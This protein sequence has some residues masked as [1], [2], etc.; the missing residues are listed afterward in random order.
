MRRTISSHRW[1]F[2]VSA[3]LSF[4]SAALAGSAAGDPQATSATGGW[5]VGYAEADIT[6][7][8]GEAMLAGFGQ[9]RQVAGTIAPLRAQALAFQDAKGHRALLITA[10]VLG[11][12]RGSVD[13]LRRRIEKAHGIPASALCLTASHTHWGPA[14]NYGANFAI[15]GLNV[16]YVKRLEETVLDLAAKA[17]KNLAP[18]QIEY[19]A[20]E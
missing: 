15:G 2:L 8:A 10:D 6:P 1:I 12:G 18:A 7:A 9:P 13:A 4:A 14:I 16:W 19:G 17:L 11:F 5:Q 20:C 3:A